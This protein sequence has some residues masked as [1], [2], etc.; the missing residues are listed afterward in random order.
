MSVRPPLLFYCQHH[1]GLG[2]LVRSLALAEALAERFEVVMVSGGVLPDG[3]RPP[4]GVR[5]VS[6]PPVGLTVEGELVSGERGRSIEEA[7]ELA[8]A[9]AVRPHPWIDTS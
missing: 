8:T 3:L 6:L 7:F 5:L 1:L 2:H 4:S 9:R